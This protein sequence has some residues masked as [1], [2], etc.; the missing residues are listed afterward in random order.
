MPHFN[1]VA[2]IISLVVVAPLPVLVFVNAESAVTDRRLEPLADNMLG[3]LLLSLIFSASATSTGLFHALGTRRSN[4]VTYAIAGA[5]GSTVLMTAADM[6]DSYF[7][8]PGIG[9]VW[10]L[11]GFVLGVAFGVAFRI[12]DARCAVR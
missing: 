5:V 12:V 10:P 9:W 6:T 7:T 11:A 3:Y 2:M 8:G 4:V 1:S